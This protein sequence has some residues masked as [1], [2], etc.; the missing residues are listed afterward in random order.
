MA[1]IPTK[2]LF[3]VKRMPDVGGHVRQSKEGHRYHLPGGDERMMLPGG[4][5]L[6]TDKSV[7]QVSTF[8]IYTQFVRLLLMID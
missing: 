4:G 8:I 2:T 6:H 1:Y 5:H 7:E 3:A